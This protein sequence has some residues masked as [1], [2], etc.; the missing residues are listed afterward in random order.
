MI[1]AAAIE[2][3]NVTIRELDDDLF[4][5]L[6]DESRDVSCK[7]QMVLVIRFVRKDGSVVERFLGVIHV[8]DTIATLLKVVVES[9]LVEHNLCLSRV[10]DQGYD[11]ASNMRGE[12]NGLK[13]L[14]L[15]ENP[16]TYYVHC[17]AHQL[18]LTLVAVVKN[19]IDVASLFTLIFSVQ[20][21]VGASCK[22]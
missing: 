11:R 17:F 1:K 10:R 19:H 4:A 21:T 2:T 16:S 15:R 6:V 7:E 12:F 18:Q 3:T 8:L 22:R 20:N 5:I 14:I 13:S 9:K